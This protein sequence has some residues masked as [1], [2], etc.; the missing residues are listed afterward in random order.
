MAH[1]SSIN[2]LS[3][4]DMP[5]YMIYSRPDSVVTAETSSSLRV[6]HV[7]LALRLQEAIHEPG[8]ECIVRAPELLPE[9]DRYGSLENFLITKL[10]D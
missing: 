9:S 5:V 7:R 4:N 2:H 3:R 8:L 1:A 10:R 6:H